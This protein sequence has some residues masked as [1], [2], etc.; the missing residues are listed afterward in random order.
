MEEQPTAN[1]QNNK[2]DTVKQCLN[3]GTQLNGEYCHNCGQHVTDHAMTIKSFILN[4]LDNT[5]LWDNQHFKTIWR[6][7]SRP[8][9]LTKE[10]AAGKFVSQVHP[11]K[12]IMFLLIVFITLFVFFGSDQNINNS[13]ESAT[14]DEFMFASLQMEEIYEDVEYLAKIKASS[15]DTVNIIAPVFLSEKYPTIIK[16]QH[17]DYDSEGNALDKWVA[18]VPHVFIED[19]ILKTNDEGIYQ[20]NTKAGIAAEDIA[21]FRAVWEQMSTL[22]S[23]YLPIILL[24]TVPFLAFSLQVVQR[25]RKCTYF[26]HFIFSMHYIAFAEVAII[27]MYLMYLIAHPS[28]TLLNIIFT[29]CSCVYFT[30]AFRVVYETSWFRSITKALLSNLIYYTICSMLFFA[31]FII[32]LIIVIE[33]F[34]V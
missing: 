17:I 8:G 16:A 12:L 30:M 27:V 3:C 1:L 26:T 29:I 32:A 6:L 33:K 15:R 13:I 21:L 4:Y 10:Y 9:M 34:D 11:L 20:F 28:L 24:L 2:I 18:I 19:E 25:S 7:I 23:Q 14:S 22:T 31:V 5:Y